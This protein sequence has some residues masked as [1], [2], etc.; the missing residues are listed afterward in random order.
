MLKYLQET[1]ITKNGLA[2]LSK[3]CPLLETIRNC[4]GKVIYKRRRQ[5]PSQTYVLAVAERP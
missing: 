2:A 5:V 4:R 3:N 1:V